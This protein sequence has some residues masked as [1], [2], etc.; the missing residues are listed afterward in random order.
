MVSF[1]P[2]SENFKLLTLNVDSNHYSN[3]KLFNAAV[4]S[5]PGTAKLHLGNRKGTNSLLS[6]AG[7]EDVGIEE[8]RIRTLDSSGGRAQTDRSELCEDRRGGVRARS[9][10]GRAEHPCVESSIDS[11]GDA[12]LRPSEEEIGNFLRTF[13]YVVK[14]VRYRTHLGLLYANWNS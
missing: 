3:V 1:E 4:G 9:A 14:T 12:R 6:D 2:S 7:V 8:V 10:Q 11:H 5:A 13:G